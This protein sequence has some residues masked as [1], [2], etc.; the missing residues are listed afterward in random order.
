MEATTVLVHVLAGS[1]GIVSG[2]VALYASKGAPLHRK[3]GMVFFCVML[4]MTFSGTVLAIVR[5]AAPAMNIPAA[6]FT[7]YLVVTGFATVRP[8]T[9]GERWLNPAALIV[10][11]GV[12]LFCLTY[13]IQIAAGVRKGIAFPFF[14]FGIVGL[15]A[16]AGDVSLIRKGGLRSLRG[17]PRLGRHLWRMCFALFIATMSFF[18]GQQRRIPE[19]LRIQPLLML[20][21]LAVLV[22]MLYWVWRV[23]VRRRLTGIADI[24]VPGIS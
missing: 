9:R 1:L 20:P 19:P 17:A 13:G 11:L 15:M 6:L 10:A 21:V 16:V 12:A 5:N 14:L 22:T 7:A 23:R 18:I 8:P 24:G 4:T 2:F 3:A